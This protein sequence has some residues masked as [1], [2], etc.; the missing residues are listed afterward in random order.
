MTPDQ[1]R[2]VQRSF[3]LIG[4]D[5]QA[6][7]RLF[8]GRLFEIDPSSKPLFRS[9]LEVQGAKLVTMLAMVVNGLDRLEPLLPAVEGLARRHVGYGVSERHYPS[10]G[11]A[12]VWALEEALGERFTREM[13]AAWIEAYSILSTTMIAAARSVVVPAV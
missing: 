9:D 7:A 8:Y 10:V 5:G 4:S 11:A 6:V 3:A 12:L 13:R 1:I 2:L